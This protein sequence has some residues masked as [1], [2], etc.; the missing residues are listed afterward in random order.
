MQ[1]PAIALVFIATPAVVAPCIDVGHRVAAGRVVGVWQWTTAASDGVRNVG[2][3]AAELGPEGLLL[4]TVIGGLTAG[5]SE[6]DRIEA[7]VTAWKG[8][9]P[10]TVMRAVAP[11]PTTGTAVLRLSLSWLCAG[12]AQAADGGAVGSTCPEGQSCRAGACRPDDRSD[13]TLPAY[14]SSGI[15]ACF[16]LESCMAGA[17]T[18]SVEASTCTV[19]AAAAPR[20]TNI[21]VVLPGGSR[22]L[23]T[24]DRCLVPLDADPA[25]GWSDDGARIAL[26]P[27]PCAA[28][29]A[30]RARAV[31]ASTACPAKTGDVTVWSKTMR[32]LL[33]G[34]V[35]AQL[36]CQLTDECSPSQWRCLGDGAN[37]Q[38]QQ[39]QQNDDFGGYHWFPADS[40][41][42]GRSCLV[43]PDTRGVGALC[44][45]STT[46]DPRCGH[47][48]LDYCDGDTHVSCMA[49]YAVAR[50][51]CGS[52]GLPGGAAATHCVSGGT[53]ASCVPPTA[54]A[55]V[56]CTG[57]RYCDGNTLVEC[58][59][60]YAVFRSSCRACQVESD[61]TGTRG[62]C[63]GALGAACSADA[64]CASGLICR[65]VGGEAATC[66]AA[67]TVSET[68]DSCL[69]ALGTGGL[70][71]TAYME[72]QPAG[73]QLA[74]I[75][76][77]CGWN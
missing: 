14:D 2:D 39:C 46:P 34:A 3:G 6:H 54:T 31:I 71:V 16:D 52:Y 33:V 32:I 77:Y 24:A 28:L 20:I 37:A 55:D 42:G 73:R 23:C 15:P 36:A 50:A 25:E 18:L 26:P 59:Q 21:A 11:L 4:P 60:G 19:P 67:C 41:T 35:A 53:G 64:D 30:G 9:T 38:V 63:D 51:A 49:G 74:C 72:L 56:R 76:G 7:S 44:V 75:A 43:V 1:I 48:W 10:F 45:L 27:A 65:P 68:G 70:P 12:T 61:A 13:E 8:A 5:T 57:D 40:C 17:Q 22:G 66:T 62:V 69:D 47:G 58:V 29:S